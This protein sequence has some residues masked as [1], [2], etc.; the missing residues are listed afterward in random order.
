MHREYAA[1]GSCG[2]HTAVIHPAP[3]WSPD[4]DA[5]PAPRTPAP[6]LAPRRARTSD[7]AV[8]ETIM[9]VYMQTVHRP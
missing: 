2:E 8:W 3:R 5:G 4:A 1:L 6:R 7:S 9:Q